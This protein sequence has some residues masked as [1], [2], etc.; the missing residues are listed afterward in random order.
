MRE[1][2]KNIGK[3]LRKYGKSMRNAEKKHFG[4]PVWKLMGKSSTKWGVK[5]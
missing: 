2:M 5:N 3:Y 4:N 1:N